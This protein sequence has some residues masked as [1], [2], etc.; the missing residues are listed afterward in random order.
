MAPKALMHLH[1]PDPETPNMF[2]RLRVRFRP[3]SVDFHNAENRQRPCRRVIR[4]GKDSQ[5]VYLASMLS[6]KLNPGTGSH[7]QSSGASL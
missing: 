3:K 1:C 6:A 2:S 7:R 4:H 5:S